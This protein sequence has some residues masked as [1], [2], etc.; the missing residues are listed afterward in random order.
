[1]YLQYI[2]IFHRISKETRWAS[3]NNTGW[4][5]VYE[6]VS[7]YP[8]SVSWDKFCKTFFRFRLHNADCCQ[9]Y[10]FWSLTVSSKRYR[11]VHSQS[12]NRFPELVLKQWRGWWEVILVCEGECLQVRLSKRPA[13]LH[14]PRAG[15]TVTV[16]G[17]LH[18]ARHEAVV[19]QLVLAIEGVWGKKRR[20]PT[21]LRS[22][23]HVGG[24][25]LYPLKLLYCCSSPQLYGACQFL[26]AHCFV[27]YSSQLYTH[28]LSESFPDATDSCFLPKSL[29]V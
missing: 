3:L 29:K 27:S 28:S 21:L 15:R 10:L 7:V 18:Q 24:V 2:C 11:S 6:R 17:Q 8:S 13:A 16:V 1:M 23:I 14:D 4:S 12:S 9:L 22:Q 19:R 25:F 5:R 26:L 20:T